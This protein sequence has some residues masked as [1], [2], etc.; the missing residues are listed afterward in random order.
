MFFTLP[1]TKKINLECGTYNFPIS[2][3]FTKENQIYYLQRSFLKH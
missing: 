3:V 1:E 2:V